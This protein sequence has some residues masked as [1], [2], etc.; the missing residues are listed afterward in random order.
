V[1]A[2]ANAQLEVVAIDGK[3]VRHSHRTSKGSL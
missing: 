3:T 2:L 1:V